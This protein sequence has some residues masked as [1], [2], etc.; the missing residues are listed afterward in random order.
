MMAESDWIIIPARHDSSRLPG[1]PLAEIDGRPMIHWV[2]ERAVAAGSEHVVIATDDER[3]QE[4]AA[5]IGARAV[6][7]SE[8][9]ES[10]TDRLAEVIDHLE[11]PDET[12]VVNLQGDEPLMPPVLLAQV[13]NLLR[14][15]PDAAMATLMVPISDREEFLSP[16]AVKVVANERA[17]AMYFSRAPIPFHRDGVPEL[18]EAGLFGFRHLGLYAYRAGFLRRFVETSSPEIERL[19]KLEQLR[20]LSM[21][22]TIAI[23]IAEVTP[24]PGVDTQAD[25][26]RVRRLLVEEAAG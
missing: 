24:P 11:L 14:A 1:K 10:G 20:A 8:G 4:A 25:L 17:E 12:V 23:E 13:A 2:Y 18:G 21:G 15:K 9:H 7:T 26:E 19:E 22:E 3:I 6:L 16:D 5:E